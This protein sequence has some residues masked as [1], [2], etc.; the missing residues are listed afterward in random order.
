MF[1]SQVLLTHRDIRL[2]LIGDDGY[3]TLI[4]MNLW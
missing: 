3:T 1:T 4:N 2:A